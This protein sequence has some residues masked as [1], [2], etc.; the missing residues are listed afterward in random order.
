MFYVEIHEVQMKW[1]YFSS[2]VLGNQSEEIVF[3]SFSLSFSLVFDVQD[4]KISS[5]L[6]SEIQLQWN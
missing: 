3:L 2:V 1:I 6:D 4:K 5:H